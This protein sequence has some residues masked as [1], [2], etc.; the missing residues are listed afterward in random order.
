M[1]VR[2]LL[3]ETL[4]LIKEFDAMTAPEQMEWINH[5]PFAALTIMWYLASYYKGMNGGEIK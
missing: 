5:N 1:E 3:K 2:Q 4:D